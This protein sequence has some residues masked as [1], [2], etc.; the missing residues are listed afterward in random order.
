[1]PLFRAGAATLYFCHR[2]LEMLDDFRANP[3]G[4]YVAF[5]RTLH[6]MPSATSGFSVIVF[7]KHYDPKFH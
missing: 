5:L 7:R 3:L 1:M 6:A 2:N 4:Y